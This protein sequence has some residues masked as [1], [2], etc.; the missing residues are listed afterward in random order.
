MSGPQEYD[1]HKTRVHRSVLEWWVVHCDLQ[2]IQIL[3]EAGADLTF[4]DE[5]GYSV[6]RRAENSGKRCTAVVDY[7]KEQLKSAEDKQPKEDL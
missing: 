2:P 5:E 7:L 1:G 4:V 3:V 6:L